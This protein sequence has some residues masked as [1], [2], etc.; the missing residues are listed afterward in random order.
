MTSE[1]FFQELDSV[2][3]VPTLPEIA[4]KV[5]RMLEEEDVS[6]GELS[7]I[8]Q[9][10]QALVT[11]ILRLINSSF[12]QFKSQIET[13][14]R[15][16]ILLGLNMVRNAVLSIS[17]IDAFGG[18]D[19][20]GRFDVKEFWYH[21]IAVAVTSKQLGERTHLELP[22]DCFV[23]GL[24]HDMGKV[25]VAQ[26]FTGQFSQILRLIRNEQVSFYEA[27][28]RL[29]PATHAEIGGYLAQKWQL[30]DSLT[31][32]IRYHHG[33]RRS[34]ASLNLSMIVHVADVIANAYKEDSEG[35]L[36]YA[37]IYPD[38]HEAMVHELETAKEW[39]PAVRG[40]IES[41]YGFMFE[42]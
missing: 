21:S 29:L 14:P 6:I 16:V 42:D 18:K 38:A 22:D 17:F 25:I 23:A 32:A 9:N 27:E 39:F 3:G 34:A 31:H 19:D 35:K 40:E 24:L 33:I 10:D 11:K 1:E 5:N 28:K 30:P 4:L 41:I 26:Y 7:R 12:Y 37:S 2:P 8:I 13:I 20:I 15:A 36:N